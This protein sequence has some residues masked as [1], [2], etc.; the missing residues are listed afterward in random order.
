EDLGVL[1]RDEEG[2][3]VWTFYLTPVELGIVLDDYDYVQ[4]LFNEFYKDCKDYSD[5]ELEHESSF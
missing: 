3:D 4:D 5:K 1:E 2:N